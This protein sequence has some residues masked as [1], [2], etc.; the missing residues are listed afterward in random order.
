MHPGKVLSEIYMKEMNIN[1]SE[2]ARKI[3]YYSC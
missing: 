1:Q 3:G 2:L